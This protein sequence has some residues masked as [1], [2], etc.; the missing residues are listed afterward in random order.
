MYT[1]PSE[2]RPARGEWIEIPA[3]AAPAS[4]PPSRP[5]RGEWIEIVSRYAG[6]VQHESRPARGEWIEM[7]TAGRPAPCPRRLAPR[8]ASGLKSSH[9]LMGGSA[10]SS[11]PARGEW[12]EIVMRCFFVCSPLSRPA[13]GEWIEI[14]V[15]QV[16]VSPPP[17]LAP[18]GA[19]GLKFHSPM[20]HANPPR[21]SPREGRVD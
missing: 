21:V 1:E 5:A 4:G 17:R 7:Q 14:P 6:N 15:P 13:R 11:R 16:I 8:G 9:P 2:S 12:I 10:L 3:T 18:R 19:S 20:P